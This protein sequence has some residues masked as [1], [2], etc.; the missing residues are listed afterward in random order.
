MRY[1]RVGTQ[2]S[3]RNNNPTKTMKIHYATLALVAGVSVAF[4]SCVAPYAGYVSY[5]APGGISTGVAWTNASY[6]ADGFPIFGYAYGRPVY[7]YTAAGAAIFT[8]GAL[9]ALCYVPHWGPASWYHGHYHYPHGIHRVPQPPRFP[10]G[11][12]PHVRP[13]AG[14]HI[15][16][17]LPKHAAPAPRPGHAAPPQHAWNR[18]GSTI[19][20]QRPGWTQPHRPSAPAYKQ[21]AHAPQGNL[22]RPAPG[23]AQPGALKPQS[24]SFGHA[25]AGNHGGI[26]TMP[27]PK[28]SRPIAT[29]PSFGSSKGS[30]PSFGSS[31]G[32]TPSFGRSSSPG[33][34]RNRTAGGFRHGGRR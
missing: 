31:R 4:S 19:A 2:N 26:S 22:N 23:K 25:A 34:V 10:A 24:P 12:A 11:H 18:P 33:M 9:T 20:P 28:N 30:A 5:S 21:P 15:G 1:H 17:G 14:A 6:D 3:P 32:S 27:A 7:G 16:P 13:P 8:I 29:A